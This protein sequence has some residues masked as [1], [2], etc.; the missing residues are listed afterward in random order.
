ME[1]PGAARFLKVVQDLI[2]L[3]P[4]LA[5]SSVVHKLY[6]DGFT[7]AG[8]APRF[9]RWEVQFRQR[10]NWPLV[11]KLSS[12]QLPRFGVLFHKTS[13]YY[14]PLVLLNAVSKH[15]FSLTGYPCSPLRYSKQQLFAII[16][17]AGHSFIL[18]EVVSQSQAVQLYSVQHRNLPVIHNDTVP[19]IPTVFQHVRRQ[20]VLPVHNVIQPFNASSNQHFSHILER[21]ITPISKTIQPDHSNNN[22]IKLKS[23][24]QKKS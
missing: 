24:F 21:T 23:Y 4:V 9:L 6:F 3:P 11:A 16:D 13:G 19:T 8:V 1:Q 14:H 17:K 15:L 10:K 7:L 2:W 12:S 5:H 22:G 20:I 18:L